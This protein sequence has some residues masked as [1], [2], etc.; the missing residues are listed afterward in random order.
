MHAISKFYITTGFH[1]ALALP[2][3]SCKLLGGGE[4][5]GSMTQYTKISHLEFLLKVIVSSW[6]KLTNFPFITAIYSIAR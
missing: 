5:A 4:P 1:P 2:W 3:E 6:G